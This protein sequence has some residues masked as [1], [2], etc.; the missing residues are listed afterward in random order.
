MVTFGVLATNSN[1]E[2]KMKT[3]AALLLICLLA[4]CSDEAST[5]NGTVAIFLADTEKPVSSFTLDPAFAAAL[6]ARSGA[7]AS[8]G[9]TLL[10]DDIPDKQIGRVVF[11][12][13][14]HEHSYP[15]MQC[16]SPLDNSERFIWHGPLND[17][18]N[19]TESRDALFVAIGLS[20]KDKLDM[21]ATQ[22]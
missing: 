17:M 18:R 7:Q 4:G 2:H 20:L 8:A 1:R 9:F 3:L 11:A 16:P 21:P 14:G 13:D 12:V 5:T 19:Q 15:I 6:H 22:R 10:E